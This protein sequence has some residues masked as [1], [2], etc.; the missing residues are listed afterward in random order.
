M[1]DAD[2]SYELDNLGPF[3]DRLR[4]GDDLVI[5]NRFEGGIEPDA[6]P[7]LHRYLGN[8]VLSALGRAMFKVPVRDFHCGLRA[9]DARPSRH[10]VCVPLA[11]SSPARC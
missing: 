11:W 9:C 10:S 3:L 1:G 7:F 5:G 2:D 6:M 4:A 8:P